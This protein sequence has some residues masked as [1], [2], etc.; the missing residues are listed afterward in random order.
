[1]KL[2]AGR[3]RTE[4]ARQTDGR[5]FPPFFWV[6]G[7]VAAVSSISNLFFQ[8][9]MRRDEKID[10]ARQSNPNNRCQQLTID[11]PN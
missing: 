3:R 2:H 10:A 9:T 5:L 4:G 1:M 11:D 7:A 6:R 8:N